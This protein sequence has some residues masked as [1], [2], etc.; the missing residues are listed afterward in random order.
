MYGMKNHSL[1]CSVKKMK[2]LLS[3]FLFV[4]KKSAAPSFYGS[5]VA[6][7]NFLFKLGVRCASFSF[8]LSFLILPVPIALFPS[9]NASYC[10]IHSINNWKPFIQTFGCM[11]RVGHGAMALMMGGRP[12]W[13]PALSRVQVRAHPNVITLV[14]A[15]RTLFE[16][17]LT[18]YAEICEARITPLTNGHFQCEMWRYNNDHTIV[19]S[20]NV[21]EWN[22]HFHGEQLQCVCHYAWN[23]VFMTECEMC[24]MVCVCVT[25]YV[26]EN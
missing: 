25:H 18:I 12:V 10:P 6:M 14:H 2:T 8:F 15:V 24:I 17:S 13:H 22:G 3:F 1:R 5:P 19:H 4:S 26:C 7:V 23:T 11:E 20:H 21:P 16:D 9:C